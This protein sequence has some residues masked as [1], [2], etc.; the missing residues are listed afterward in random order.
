M[1]QPN[2][3]LILK[4]NLFFSHRSNTTYWSTLSEQGWVDEMD[5]MRRIISE[6]ANV[7]PEKITG[8]F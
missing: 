8:N 4:I 7:P 5:G 2:L 6:F 3:K 1:K